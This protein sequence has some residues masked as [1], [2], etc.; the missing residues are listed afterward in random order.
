MRYDAAIV[1]GGAAGMAAALWC[2]DLG[3]SA[4]LLER[5]KQLGGQL[6]KIYNRV[7]NH[8]GISAADGA[9][10]RDRFVKQIENFDFT[11]RCST[12]V[13]KLDLRERFVETVRGEKISARAF[14]IATG[15]SRRKL[16]VAGEDELQNSGIL[17]SGKRDGK[18]AAGK[19][20]IV[21]GGGDAALE[22]ALILAETA[23]R[24]TVVHRRREFRARREFIEAAEKKSEN[25]FSD[26]ND[27]Q[28]NHRNKK[29][30]S[31]RRQKSF[32]QT[33]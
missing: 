28:K 30:R 13:K 14:I 17:S 7:E 19:T 20:A 3:L 10:L 27:C 32:R 31:R 16:N 29:S 1:G 21:I 26:R 8:L 6:E 23:R 5:E 2:A 11:R 15:V 4:V 33:G 9:E 24:V 22:N 12:D 25:Q 18:K